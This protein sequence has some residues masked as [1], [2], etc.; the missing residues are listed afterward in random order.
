[1]RHLH[2]QVDKGRKQV[3]SLANFLLLFIN[4]TINFSSHGDFYEVETSLMLEINRNPNKLID[5]LNCMDFNLFI[6]YT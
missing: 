1:M 6:R 3:L 5:V 4:W 2:L